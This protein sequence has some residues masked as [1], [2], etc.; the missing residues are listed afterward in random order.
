[1]EK[2]IILNIPLL[3]GENM[4]KVLDILKKRLTGEN[5]WYMRVKTLIPNKNKCACAI[6]RVLS[7]SSVD[8]FESI[9]NSDQGKFNNF[10]KKLGSSRYSRIIGIVDFS[11]LEIEEL[12]CMFNIKSEKEG[13][14]PYGGPLVTYFIGEIN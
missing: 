5:D 12:F 9:E 10:L 14:M 3:E 7:K 8:F 6:L 13:Y 11:E 1:M 2:I 4:I